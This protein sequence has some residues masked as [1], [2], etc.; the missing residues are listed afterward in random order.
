MSDARLR[1]SAIGRGSRSGC[2]LGLR[3]PRLGCGMAPAGQGCP[4]CPPPPLTSSLPPL[5]F[6]PRTACSVPTTLRVSGGGP[7]WGLGSWGAHL[8]PAPDVPGLVLTACVCVYD[9]QHFRPGDVI[10][11][12]TDGTGGC[13]SARCSADGSIER[14]VSPCSTTSPAPASTFSF[15]TSAPGK[16]DTRG[17]RAGL[18]LSPRRQ[19]PA[20]PGKGQLSPSPW[21]DCYPRGHS[22]V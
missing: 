4:T 19:E 8:P 13:L 14:G 7:S 12:T 6:A 22:Q 18:S 21:Q 9:G 2:D 11:H 1:L 5:A 17:H 16:A 3:V 20:V 15:S 10:Y